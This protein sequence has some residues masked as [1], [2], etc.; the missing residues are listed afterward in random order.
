MNDLPEKDT[1]ARK[2]GGSLCPRANLV[3]KLVPTLCV[4]MPSS[5]LRVVRS[6][7]RA[8]ERLGRHSHA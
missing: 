3:E 2:S 7:Q 6:R 8:A 1:G 4:G 5:T